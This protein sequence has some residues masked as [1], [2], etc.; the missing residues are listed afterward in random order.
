[1]ASFYAE[2]SENLKYP[3]QAKNLGIEGRVYVEFIV[4]ENG[5]LTN[6]NVLKGIGAGCD[7]AAIDVVQNSSVA[8]QPG[9]HDG[10]KIKQKIVLPINFRLGEKE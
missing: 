10:K 5:N 4:D 7:K 9:I 1:M 8:W 2:I 3:V 6:F